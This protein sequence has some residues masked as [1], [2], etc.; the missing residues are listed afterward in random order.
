MVDDD[1]R[2]R[3]TGESVFDSQLAHL[4]FPPT[5]AETSQMPS[6][7]TSS[8]KSVVSSFPMSS[9]LFYKNSIFRPHQQHFR[10]FSGTFFQ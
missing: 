2:D 8:N 4:V 9:L 6:N 5:A 1:A 7:I 10:P 3:L